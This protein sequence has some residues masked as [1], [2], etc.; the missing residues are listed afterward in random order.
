VAW[1][2]EDMDRLLHGAQQRS[3]AAGEVY[4]QCH[5]VSVLHRESKNNDTKL[6]PTTSAKI[7]RFLKFF[8]RTDLVV[9]LQQNVFKYSTTLKSRGSIAK[10]LRCNELLYY[11]FIIQSA[12]KRVFKIGEHLAK[13]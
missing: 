9:N 8:S 13:L 2:E 4:G 10:R 3:G 6:L 11:T 5:V 7:N 12:G 1:P